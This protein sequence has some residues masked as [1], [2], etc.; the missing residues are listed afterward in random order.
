MSFGAAVSPDLQAGGSGKACVLSALTCGGHTA[1]GAALFHHSAK[2]AFQRL[3]ASVCGT[4]LALC[5]V[6]FAVFMGTLFQAI[7]LPWK[8]N[9]LYE[10]S[11]N[12][13][14]VSLFLQVLNIG[15]LFFVF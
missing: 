1:Q 11:K 8:I 12:G 14:E 6:S 13:H 4:L 5:T 9:S 15:M 10:N 7:V 3:S 2:V